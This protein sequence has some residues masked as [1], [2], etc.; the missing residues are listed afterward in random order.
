MNKNL[1]FSIENIFILFE[2]LKSYGTY[3]YE[4]LTIWNDTEDDNR[5]DFFLKFFSL[6]HRLFALH[7]FLRYIIRRLKYEDCYHLKVPLVTIQIQ[8]REILLCLLFTLYYNE[9][10]KYKCCYQLKY[11]VAIMI[12]EKNIFCSIC[13]IGVIQYVLRVYI[14]LTKIEIKML[15]K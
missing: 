15:L 4:S 14:F 6:Y 1:L 8:K 2:Q 7:D 5:W 12:K 9:R 10:L 3:G 13:F 11:L